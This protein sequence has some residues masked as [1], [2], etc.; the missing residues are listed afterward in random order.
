MMMIQ[1]TIDIPVSRKVHFDVA[2]PETAQCGKAPVIL[3][4]PSV[5]IQ[6][7]S[8]ETIAPQKMSPVF[9]KAL[10]EAR[11]KRLY[12]EAHPDELRETMQ[13]LQ[14]GLPLFGGIG[15]DEFKRRSR[16]EWQNPF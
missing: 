4:F 8:A 13:R 1:Q 9:E 7:K 14:E 12:W 5:T 15:A 10:E 6:N 11:Q 2:L 3:N 16:N